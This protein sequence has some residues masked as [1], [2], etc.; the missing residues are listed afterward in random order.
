MSFN[1]KYFRQKSKG[2][3]QLQKG[4]TELGC[5]FVLTALQIQ[6]PAATICVHFNLHMSIR[7]RYSIANSSA[8]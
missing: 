6:D 3:Q 7:H 8:D 5:I 1:V 4:N 2:N